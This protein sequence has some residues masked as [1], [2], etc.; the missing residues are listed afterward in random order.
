MNTVVNWND[1]KKSSL[2]SKLEYKK[3]SLQFLPQSLEEISKL[4]YFYFNDEKLKVSYLIDI[5]HN[6]LLKYYFK[7][8]NHFSLSS[9]VLK[10]KYGHLYNY[11]INYLID[12][13]MIIMILNYKA[14]TRSRVYALSDKILK[15]KIIRYK[16]FDKTLLKK[17]L[18]KISQIEVDKSYIDMDIKSKLVSDLFHV[19][20]ESDRSIFYLDS[21]KN[22]SI[23]IYNRNKYSV[24]CI[25]DK[26]IFYH[27]D[28]Y[29]RF[30]TNFTILKSFIRKN[31]LL[32]DGEETCEL[33]IVNSQPLFL[34]KLIQ[35][36]GTKWV[37]KDELDLFRYLTIKGI[38][39]KYLMNELNISKKS[40]VKELTYKVLFGRNIKNSKSDVMFSS[41]FPTIH[42]FIKLYKKE[43]GDYKILAH[44]LQKAESN[45]IFNK[46]I[47][48][49]ITLYPDIKLITVH[50]SIIIPIKYR[51][52]VSSIFYS[53]IY[54]ELG[55][56]SDVLI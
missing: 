19:Q 49:I 2:I 56:K 31:C 45:L 54:D 17:Y 8:N 25:G 43:M 7:R 4:K 6:L 21:L 35:D 30:H 32:I 33:D 51:E 55:Y 39:Y 24:E 38:Y 42:Y 41:I 5:I 40:E 12:N 50:D 16:N 48:Q 9:L 28:G 3:N 29:G 23:D 52:E 37:N 20:I 1:I 22:E 27:F 10:D 46:I 14:G 18:L 15:D 34:A 11:Y 26:H 36:S 47:R 53:K 13:K 44:E